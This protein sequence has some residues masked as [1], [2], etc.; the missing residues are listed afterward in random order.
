MNVAITHE[1]ILQVTQFYD[2]LKEALNEQE[3]KLKNAGIELAPKD[4]RRIFSEA[5]SNYRNVQG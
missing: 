3:T 1:V 5:W 2:K 4:R